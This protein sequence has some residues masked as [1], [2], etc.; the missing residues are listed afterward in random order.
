MYIYRVLQASPVLIYFANIFSFIIT[1]EKVYLY[2]MFGLLF[3]YSLITPYLKVVAQHYF[4]DVEVFKR[5]NPPQEGCGTFADVTLPGSKSFGMP[6][7]H[8]ACSTFSA[9]FWTL[10]LLDDPTRIAT[11]EIIVIWLLSFAVLWH[12]VATGCHNILQVSV[13][14]LYGLLTGYLYYN[15]LKRYVKM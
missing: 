11:L 9:I 2:F 13:G 12:R 15:L 10:Y 4:G 1:G 5:P 14:G 8:A 3:F 7:G 6:S